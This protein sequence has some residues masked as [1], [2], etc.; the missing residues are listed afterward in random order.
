[1]RPDPSID[2][3]ISPPCSPSVAV[4]D[5]CR[6]CSRPH[7]TRPIK[8]TVQIYALGRT[9]IMVRRL[10]AAGFYTDD[11]RVEPLGCISVAGFW[12]DFN[13]QDFNDENDPKNRETIRYAYTGDSNFPFDNQRPFRIYLTRLKWNCVLAL[14]SAANTP[15][16]I[17]EHNPRATRFERH[18][19][20]TQAGETGDVPHVAAALALDPLTDVIVLA[21]QDTASTDK[22]NDAAMSHRNAIGVAPAATDVRDF[23]RLAVPAKRVRVVGLRTLEQL[24]IL[25][26]YLT[27]PHE[28]DASKYKP[29]GP[30]SWQ[31]APDVV[32]TLFIKV[33]LSM[34]RP[35]PTLTSLQQ[36]YCF[37]T[38]AYGGRLEY[39]TMVVG[40][41]TTLVGQKYQDLGENEFYRVLRIALTS[42]AIT[43]AMIETWAT[44]AGLSLPANPPT[45]FVSL[46]LLIV[47]SRY[48]GQNAGGGYNP[49][50]DSD[51]VGQTSLIAR[52]Q[53]LGLTVITVGHDPDGG[54]TPRGNIHL[55]EFW[56]DP[57]SPFHGQGRP[58]QGSLYARFLAL[59]HRVVQVGQKTGGMDNAALI[60][61]PTVYIEDVDSFSIKR[62]EK[63]SERMKRYQCA[64]ITL[65][66]T[67]VGKAIR[68]RSRVH[69]SCTLRQARDM[70]AAEP[71]K[72]TAGY[73]PG[74]LDD[75]VNEVRKMY[76]SIYNMPLL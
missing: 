35:I 45:P 51:P 27:R 50:G 48:S 32:Q 1:M 30:A 65:P 29:L 6:S 63:W 52:G 58:G 33:C 59:R 31:S 37:Y 41:A 62:M 47:W 72:Y 42:T 12:V 43:P 22:A 71:A 55:G 61:V 26:K 34:Q 39:P 3:P 16:R 24:K 20:V 23:E 36:E 18:L 17:G 38:N 11:D 68:I 60:G 28:G 8:L 66:P 4:R 74:D 10:T 64:K 13:L 19:I 21:T 53:A 54:T 49:A 14:P 67:R 69:G 25:F 73:L 46:N 7:I 15:Y 75:I 56:K 40:G 76:I 57:N 44:T 2:R 9:H 5:R 70:V